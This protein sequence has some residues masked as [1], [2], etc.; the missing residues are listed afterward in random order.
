[1]GASLW[2]T[3]VP[4]RELSFLRMERGVGQV[5]WVIIELVTCPGPGSDWTSRPGD[6]ASGVRP[7]GAPAPQS[8][9]AQRGCARWGLREALH[10]SLP[11]EASGPSAG[12][13]LRVGVGRRG[14]VPGVLSGGASGC[15][16]PTSAPVEPELPGV[17][18]GGDGGMVAL[19]LKGHVPY[20]TT[21]RNRAQGFCVC[22]PSGG[23]LHFL[24]LTEMVYPRASY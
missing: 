1:M 14:R 12:L 21:L 11:A 18:W 5:S 22:R 2:E 4:R 9:R 7:P 15:L 20:T 16:G 13:C 19:I 10:G 24:K 6:H 8:L 3:K 17:G 23:L